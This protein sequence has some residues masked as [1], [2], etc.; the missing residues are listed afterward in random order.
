MN[1]QS[2]STILYIIENELNKYLKHL[3]NSITFQNEIYDQ[4]NKDTFF[5]L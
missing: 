3:P 1:L 5:I 4:D 2:L